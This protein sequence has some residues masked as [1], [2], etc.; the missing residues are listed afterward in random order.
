MAKTMR[1]MRRELTSVAPPG[2]AERPVAP[3]P[4]RRRAALPSLFLV[5]VMPA[6]ERAP[7]QD[8]DDQREDDHFLEGA[9][10]EGTEAFEAAP[11]QGAERGGRVAGQAAE[12][13]GDE[14][15]QADQEARV[16]EDGRR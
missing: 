1:A 14:A 8:R 5:V 3:I 15:F 6:L 12:D 11:Q 9:G 13:G 16:V 7:Q 2:L 10:I 4:R